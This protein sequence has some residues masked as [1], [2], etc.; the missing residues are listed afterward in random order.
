M[1]ALSIRNDLHE[2]LE[3]IP[4]FEQSW[5]KNFGKPDRIVSALEGGYNLHALARSVEAHIRA[6]LGDG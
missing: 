6:F 2:F 3:P 5:E 4:G 1:N